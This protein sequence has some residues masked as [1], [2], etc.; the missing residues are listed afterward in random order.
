MTAHQT[1]LDMGQGR[2]EKAAYFSTLTCSPGDTPRTL[3][4]CL[5]HL[6]VNNPA[7][8][9]GSSSD[10]ALSPHLRLTRPKHTRN[11]DGDCGLGQD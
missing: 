9:P 5:G 7:L 8:T 4:L 11:S 1:V 2:P 6:T 3:A 10:A